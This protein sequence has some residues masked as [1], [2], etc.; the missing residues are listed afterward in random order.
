M[1]TIMKWIGW[2]LGWLMWLIYYFIP[3]YGIA[4][5]LFT[6]ITRLVL[7]PLSIKQHKSTIK[8]QLIQPKILEIQSKY[9]N[10]PTKMNEEMQE[11]YRREN[12]S[13]TAGCLPMLIQFPIL[14]GLIDVIYRPLSH[15]MRVGAETISAIEQILTNN[16]IA[17]TEYTKEITML[18]S[19]KDNPE[20]FSSIGQETI[21][22]IITL[23]TR[24][25]GLD[26]SIIPNQVL[27]LRDF[28]SLLNPII[29]IPILSGVTALLVSLVSI[30]TSSATGAAAAQTRTMM[31][32]MPLLSLWFTFG[33]PAG[34]GFYW[35]LTN[36]FA[37]LQNLI[38]FKVWNPREAAEKIK[39]EEEARK[40]REREEKIEAKRR[41]KQEGSDASAQALSQKELNRI[42]LAEARRRNAEKYGDVYVDVTDDDLR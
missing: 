5:I 16:Q 20:L 8:M 35:T 25:L 17:F 15:I 37:L 3:N 4:L 22:H 36:I 32:L 2:P 40:A 10:N 23:D 21:N 29:L 31:L 33:V 28:S 38:F 12:Y 41:A 27:S 9:K 11:L 42:R 18:S 13:M 30:K 7:V 6:V 26:L 34:V 19:I 24:F 1:R 39:A 14:F